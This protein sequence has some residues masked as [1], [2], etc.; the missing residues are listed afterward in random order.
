MNFC[1]ICCQIEEILV[2]DGEDNEILLEKVGGAY[3]EDIIEESSF[4]DGEDNE[5]LLEKV[6]SYLEDIVEGAFIKLRSVN[7]RT[8][9]EI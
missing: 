5:M 8:I 3:L 7:S 6:G 4:E 9:L 1:S 2:S